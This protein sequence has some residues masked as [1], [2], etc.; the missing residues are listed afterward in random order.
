MFKILFSSIFLITLSSNVVLSQSL[1]DDISS[2][3]EKENI[4]QEKIQTISRD[5]KIF[6]LTNSNRILGKGDFVTLTINDKEPVV[7]AVVGKTHDKKA[8][9]KILKVYSLA[10]WQ[11][12]GTGVTVGVLRGDDSSLFLD[13]TKDSSPTADNEQSRIESEEDLYAL[14]AELTQDLDSFSQDNRHIKPD[15]L[16]SAAWGQYSY[17]NSLKPETEREAHDQFSFNWAYQFSDNYWAEGL[18]GRTQ[19]TGL[20]AEG[21]TTLINNFTV[22]LKYTFKAPFYSFIMPYA[23]YQ[24]YMV[25]SPDAGK[26]NDAALNQ[27]QNSF[28]ADLGQDR[29]VFGVT[30]LRRLVPG[31]FIK[32]DL[33]TDIMN[34]GFTVEF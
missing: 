29:P 7:R 26:T 22:R 16:V 4:F 13:K 12:L 9:I 20:P 6:I 18:Y 19:I 23:G 17:D 1:V 27:K 30:L 34:I 10:R 32:A 28:I 8:G 2:P 33:G 5:Q 3:Y 31:W 11:T 21:S 14:E 25:S 24:I 15:N